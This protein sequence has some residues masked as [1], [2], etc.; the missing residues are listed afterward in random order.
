LGRYQVSQQEVSVQPIPS[1][2]SSAFTKVAA[3]A[4]SVLDAI[5]VKPLD[6]QLPVLMMVY[7]ALKRRP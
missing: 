5:T 7:S 2:E 4:H 1:D 6:S 3:E